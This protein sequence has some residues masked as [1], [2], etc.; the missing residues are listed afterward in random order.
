MLFLFLNPSC[1]PNKQQSSRLHFGQGLAQQPFVGL[2]LRTGV[3]S[4]VS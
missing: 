2:G 3:G 1:H 4:G